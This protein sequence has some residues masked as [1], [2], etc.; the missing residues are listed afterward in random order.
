[1]VGRTISH[2][3]VL[4]KLGGG[5]TGVVYKAED[6]KLGRRPAAGRAS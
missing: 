5:G 2:Y 6:T 4:E 3:R 1:M